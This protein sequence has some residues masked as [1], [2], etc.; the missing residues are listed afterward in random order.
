MSRVLGER[1]KKEQER[2][3]AWGKITARIDL[4]RKNH[5]TEAKTNSQLAERLAQLSSMM[6]HLEIS[7]RQG[8]LTVSQFLDSNHARSFLKD[9][10]PQRKRFNVWKLAE[11]FA[12]NSDAEVPEELLYEGIDR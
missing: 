4:F 7:F 6:H 11:H 10:D 9:E 12:T 1:Y 3:E 2:K 5:E 8:T